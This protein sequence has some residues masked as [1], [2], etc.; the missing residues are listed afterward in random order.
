VTVSVRHASFTHRSL[1][2]GQAVNVGV[3][4]LVVAQHLWRR[5]GALLLLHGMDTRRVLTLFRLRAERL[6]AMRK[7]AA[8]TPPPSSRRLSSGPARRGES[9]GS[10]TRTSCLQTRG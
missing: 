5:A 9:T 10:R 3:S 1:T 8:R 4:G 6:G 2:R 7:A